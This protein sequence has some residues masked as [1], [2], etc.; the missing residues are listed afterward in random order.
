MRAAHCHPGGAGPLAARKEALLAAA[1]IAHRREAR[2][3]Q[4]MLVVG[5]CW[6]RASR[7]R[8]AD[9]PHAGGGGGGDLPLGGR[10]L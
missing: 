8:G 4:E 9:P 6:L 5:P 1:G 3:G 10:Y 7:H 2:G